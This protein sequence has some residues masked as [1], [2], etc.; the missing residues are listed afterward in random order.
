MRS[1]ARWLATDAGEKFFQDLVLPLAP[2]PCLAFQLQLRTCKSPCSTRQAQK[3]AGGW[4][5]TCS[6][7]PLS[8]TTSGSPGQT[9]A[10]RARKKIKQLRRWTRQ[11]SK[12]HLER[13]LQGSQQIPPGTRQSSNSRLSGQACNLLLKNDESVT[14]RD[15]LLRHKQ[16]QKRTRPHSQMHL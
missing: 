7:A 8:A 2:L 11:H 1:C 12:A 3:R 15:H 5:P 4:Q 10:P 6:R 13:A 14:K 16:Q 9:G